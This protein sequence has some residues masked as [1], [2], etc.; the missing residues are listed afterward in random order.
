MSKKLLRNSFYGVF[1]VL[2]ASTLGFGPS[3]FHQA[4]DLGERG[5]LQKKL[6]RYMGQTQFANPA[7]ERI[8]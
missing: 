6:S 1:V 7:Y 8:F 5:D 4:P 3:V 2:V